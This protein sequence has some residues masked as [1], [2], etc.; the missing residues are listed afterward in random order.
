MGH[1][2]AFGP[3]SAALDALLADAGGPRDALLLAKSQAF[4]RPSFVALC[5]A[6]EEPNWTAAV[7]WR[8]VGRSPFGR[9]LWARDPDAGANPPVVHEQRDPLKEF[10]R[11]ADEP[12]E[13][14]PRRVLAFAQRWG[15]LGLCPDHH[16]P[17]SHDVRCQVLIWDPTWAGCEDPAAWLFYARLARD[18]LKA[19]RELHNE[20]PLSPALASAALLDWPYQLDAL[21]VPGM[22]FRLARLVTRLLDFG[23]VRVTFNWGHHDFPH[24][25]AAPTQPHLSLGEGGTIF[26]EL[27][28]R[29][30]LAAARRATD[31][32]IEQCTNCGTPIERTRRGRRGYRVFCSKEDCQRAKWRMAKQD[33]RAGRPRWRHAKGVRHG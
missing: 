10:V 22:Q 23:A 25:S 7:S 13:R 26:G 4:T 3:R 6:D 1:A 14:V 32:E 27:A 11:L 29:L 9:L 21:D 16:L 8:A 31:T 12:L 18:L 28:L 19:A 5:A 24:S 33:Q 2:D 20:H 15:V 17:A 30:A